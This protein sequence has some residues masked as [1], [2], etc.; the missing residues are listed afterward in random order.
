MTS[1]IPPDIRARLKSLRISSRLTPNGQ[2][3]G[4]HAGRGRGAG[5]EFAQYR[6]YGQ[7]D[8]PRSIDWKLFARSDRYFVRD[9]TPATVP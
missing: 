7:G 5:L 6:S 9:A 2:G 1:L 8:E 3:L 4:L